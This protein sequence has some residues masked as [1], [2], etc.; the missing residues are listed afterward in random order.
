MVAGPQ[1]LAGNYMHRRDSNPSVLDLNL[2]DFTRHS[3]SSALAGAGR[4]MKSVLVGNDAVLA[5]LSNATFQDGL[6]RAGIHPK[7]RASDLSAEEV[8]CLHGVI[9]WAIW[10][11]LRLGGRVGFRDVLGDEV[12]YGPAWGLI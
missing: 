7:R 1:E 9:K 8:A 4:A 10:A 5:G 6:F 2:A 12:R 11:P 3:F